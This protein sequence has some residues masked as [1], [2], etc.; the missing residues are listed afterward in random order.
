M[1][2][3]LSHASSSDVSTRA[4]GVSVFSA[5]SEI[6]ASSPSSERRLSNVMA[7]PDAVDPSSSK[8]LF[9]SEDENQRPLRPRSAEP[10]TKMRLP[11]NDGK[12]LFD[13]VDTADFPA[14]IGSPTSEASPRDV[15]ERS[16]H[17]QIGALLSAKIVPHPDHA[18]NARHTVPTESVHSAKVVPKAKPKPKSRSDASGVEIL[19]SPGTS[20]RRVAPSRSETKPPS[21][22]TAQKEM[23]RKLPRHSEA[24]RHLCAPRSKQPPSDGLTRSPPQL[25]DSHRHLNASKETLSDSIRCCT[26]TER[27]PR[28]MSVNRLVLPSRSTPSLELMSSS[29]R[30]AEASQVHR[31]GMAE[32]CSPG[33]RQFCTSRSFLCA[34]SLSESIL[35]IDS[36][37]HPWRSDSNRSSPQRAESR[38]LHVS[39]CR[40]MPSGVMSVEGAV[41]SACAG[42]PLS[43]VEG[44]WQQPQSKHVVAS[45]LPCAPVA[46]HATPERQSPSCR[47]RSRKEALRRTGSAQ[48]CPDASVSSKPWRGAG[49]AMQSSMLV[50]DRGPIFTPFGGA[51]P[52]S[53]FRLSS[54]S[55]AV[56]C[57][58]L[59]VN[60]QTGATRNDIPAGDGHDDMMELS[61]REQQMLHDLDAADQ[62]VADLCRII[63]QER[64][65]R[66]N[67]EASLQSERALRC[68]GEMQIRKLEADMD[69]ANKSLEKAL[70][71]LE[72]RGVSAA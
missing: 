61:P 54:S 12:Q 34:D 68:S 53:R 58:T 59:H 29:S 23:H 14:K 66:G 47:E 51:S 56:A 69:E 9:T 46:K 45:N 32:G 20:P 30:G 35:C 63:Q 17:S 37:G 64:D 2:P 60:R 40:S 21:P 26:S 72:Q 52:A 57:D 4:S 18:F 50:A 15:L 22:Y 25:R 39:A 11:S 67:L 16:A 6:C 24:S 55:P 44:H 19:T 3:K 48:W 71:A 7:T 65:L 41:G 62:R 43:V 49:S 42:R 33:H 70:Q 38:Q 13:N 5:L 31:H 28:P 10:G 27:S 36:Q 1:E 8:S